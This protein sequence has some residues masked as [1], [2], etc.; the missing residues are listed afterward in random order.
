[1]LLEI[2]DFGSMYKL[3][4]DMWNKVEGKIIALSD[5]LESADDVRKIFG[6]MSK[7]SPRNH[8]GK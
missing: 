5:A 7:Q 1:M 4:K 3:Y 6:S 8:F 2:F